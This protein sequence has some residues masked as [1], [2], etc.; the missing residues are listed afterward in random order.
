MENMPPGVGDALR[1]WRMEASLGDAFSF[2]LS[3]PF[4]LASDPLTNNGVTTCL[5][6]HLFSILAIAACGMMSGSDCSK[7]PTN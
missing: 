5:R 1:L 6:P 7:F 3:L 4:G 2:L